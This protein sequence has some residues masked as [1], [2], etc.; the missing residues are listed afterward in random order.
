MP[1]IQVVKG[2]EVRGVL[3]DDGDAV[4]GSEAKVNVVIL[5]AQPYSIIGRANHPMPG[6]S[7]QVGQEIGIR[8]VVK[9]QV[10][11]HGQPLPA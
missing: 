3:R 2:L 7:K 9:I 1:L 6:L 4:C 10:E 11:G 5:A 8:A